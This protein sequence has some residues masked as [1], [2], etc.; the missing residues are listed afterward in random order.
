M[1]KIYYLKKKSKL[2]Y[3]LFIEY[4]LC[5][6]LIFRGNP[7]ASCGRLAET[8][9]LQLDVQFWMPYIS[10]LRKTTVDKYSSC[11]WVF[12]HFYFFAP[13]IRSRS[14]ETQIDSTVIFVSGFIFRGC[15]L[16]K[17]CRNA[18]RLCSFITIE[19]RKRA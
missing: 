4:M 16:K 11:M 8:A 6:L 15:R 19:L 12:P 13:R 18:Y 7:A 2:Y 5:T 14:T 10:V 1:N 3:Q 9:T 17:N